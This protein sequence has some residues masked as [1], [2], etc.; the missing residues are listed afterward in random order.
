M[1][2]TLKEVNESRLGSHANSR[3]LKFLSFSCAQFLK[4]GSPGCVVT[5]ILST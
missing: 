3:K 5:Q 1:I 4:V 2:Q